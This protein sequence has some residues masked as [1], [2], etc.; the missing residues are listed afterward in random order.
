MKI[1]INRGKEFS[2]VN[3]LIMPTLQALKIVNKKLK[4]GKAE[5]IIDND[6]T[7]MYKIN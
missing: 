1:I 7:L 4:E 6:L 3:D 5:I 2:T